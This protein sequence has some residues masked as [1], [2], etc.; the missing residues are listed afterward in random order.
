MDRAY[1]ICCLLFALILTGGCVNDAHP[2]STTSEVVQ[3]TPAA[4][5][6][7]EGNI[8]QTPA[9]TPTPDYTSDVSLTDVK[10][11]KPLIGGSIMFLKVTGL[12]TN[13]GSQTLTH[14]KLH[15]ELMDAQGN[16]IVETDHQYA[17]SPMRPGD[18]WEFDISP[19]CDTENGSRVE[20]YRVSV[21]EAW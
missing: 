19:A 16:S 8:H 13:T 7:V 3:T 15:V 14:I 4:S 6:V 5:S 21:A 2:Q 1:F 11:G 10:Y 12:A 18:G 17:H 20:N 9:P